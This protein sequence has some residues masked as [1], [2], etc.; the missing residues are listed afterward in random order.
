MLDNVLEAAE[1]LAQQGV[2]ATVLRLLSVSDLAVD[3]IL[4]QMPDNST[5]IVA[6][7]ACTGSGIKEALAWELKRKNPECCVAGIDL[8]AEFVT[9]GNQ[10]KLYECC[11][12]DGKSIAEYTKEVLSK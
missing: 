6:E 3:Q 2:E 9:H 10:K 12:L 8:G 7:E 5:V 4:C 1:L 11:G